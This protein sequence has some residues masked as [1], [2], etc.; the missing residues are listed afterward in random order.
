MK[1]AFK[2]NIWKMISTNEKCYASIKH[3]KKMITTEKNKWAFSSSTI[4]TP[5]NRDSLETVFTTREC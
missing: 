3:V 4:N 1:A 2:D 5:M